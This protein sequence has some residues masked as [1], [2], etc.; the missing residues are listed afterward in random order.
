MK[1][2]GQSEDNNLLRQKAEAFL[3]SKKLNKN[4][5]Y[6]ETEIRKLIHELHVFQIE[7]EMQNE[8]FINAK[9]QAE[10]ESAKYTHL[11]DYAPSAYFT[12]NCQSEIIELNI[13]GSEMLGENRLHLINKQFS[14]FIS[15]DSMASFR[16]FLK[17]IF[18]HK[19][20]EYC[21]LNL[22][23]P[24]NSVKYIHLDGVISKDGK[25]C[26]V[27]AADL[28]ESKISSE[29]LFQS[30]ERYKALF[31]NNHA[32][33]LLID[34][35]NGKIK[36]A[37]P[38]ACKF[39][40]WSHYAICKK[41]ISEINTLS[42]EEINAEM[43]KAANEKRIQFYFNHRLA[44]GEIRNVEVNSGP[45]Q[46][47]NTKLLY[48]LIHDITA[49]KTIEEKLQK[50][51]ETYRNLVESISEAIY[52]IDC[53]GIIKYVSPSI[54]TILGYSEQEL[55]GKNFIEFIGE[56]AAHL[57]ARLHLLK[58]EKVLVNDYKINNNTGISKWIRFSSNAIIEDGIFKG[59]SG[60]LTDITERKNAEEKLKKSEE[61]YRML[62]ESI[63]DV[64]YEISNEGIVKYV[65]PS[66][67]RVLGYTADEVIG[68]NIIDFIY[69]EDK[70]MIYER[71]SKL[72]EKDYSYLE[73]RYVNKKGN[74]CWV[75][76]STNAIIENGKMTG[77][78]GMLTDIT[79]RKQAENALRE[80]ESLYRAILNASPED[81]TIADLNGNIQL[82]SPKGIIM[83]GFERMEQILNRN[84][85]EFLIPE[86]RER[87]QDVFLKLYQGISIGNAEYHGIKAD[88]SIF[89]I[90]V[91]AEFIRNSEGVPTNMVFI[92]RDITESV[93]AKKKLIEDQK[94]FRVLNELMSDYIFKLNMQSD[95]NYKMS[96]IAGNYTEATGRS[97]GEISTPSDW[98]NALHPDDL[99]NLYS[100]LNQVV[101]QKQAVDLECR[102]YTEDGKFRWLNVIAT[103]EIDTIS[104]KVIGIFGSVR[105]ITEKK[106]SIQNLLESEQKYFKLIENLHAG[107]VVH[108]PDSSIMFSNSEASELLG[109]SQNQLKGRVAIDT[110][111]YFM[112]EHG[113]KLAMEEYPVV[114]VISSLKPLLNQT[115]A[116][117]RPS[118][119]DIVWVQV[120]AYPEFT[121]EG[122]L[123]QVVVTF[124]DISEIIEAEKSLR[125][126]EEKYRNI[127]ENIL[128]VYY[129]A[130]IDGTLLEISPSIEFISKGQYNRD[131]LIGKS[132][133]SFYSDPE[134]R[135]RFFTYIKKQ[136]KVTDYELSFYNK[137]GTIV[138]ISITSGLLYDAEGNPV[139]IIGS[140]RD[141]TDRKIVEKALKE[142]ELNYRT[143]VNSGQALIWTATPDKKCN[144]FN[145]EWLD[146]TGRT[147][148]QELG[149]GWSEGVHPE[150]IERCFSI[151]TSSFDARKSFSMDYRMR[152]HDG[153]YHWL[154][155]DGKPRYNSLGEFIGYIGHC[156]D[157]TERIQSGIEIKNN[158]SVLSNLIMNMQE[159]ILLENF[160]RKILLCNQLFCDMYGIGAPPEVLVGADCSESAEQN[161]IYFRN[162]EKFVR[163]IELILKNKQ[164]VFNEELELM[165]GRFFER[166]YIPTY[167]EN[168]YNG[169]L[170]KYRDITDRKQNQ[171][172]IEES[173]ERFR[174]VVAQSEEVV[175]EVDANGLYTY[176]SPLAMQIY[177]YLPEQLVGKIHFYDLHPKGN[178]E[179]LKTAAFEMFSKKENFHNFINTIIRFDGREIT[180]STNGQPIIDEKGFLLGYR[181]LDADIT[182]RKRA[183]IELS[184]SEERYR[185]ITER[186]NDLIFIFRLKPE[187]GFDYVSPSSERITGYTPED[188]YKDPMLGMKLVHPD[189]LHLLK[190]LQNGIVNEE[191]NT[192]RW[193][194]KDG[195]I[196]WT[197]SQ[198]IPI[199]D[200]NGVLVAIQGKAIDVTERKQSEQIIHTR[201][202]LNEYAQTHSKNEIQQKLLDE[203]EKITNSQIG[204]FHF[205]NSDQRSLT[206]QCWSSNTVKDK[207]KAEGKG[208]HYGIDKAGVWVDCVHERKA[209]IHNDYLSLP[210]RKGLPEGHAKVVRELVVPVFRNEKI[211]AIVGIGNKPTDYTDKDVEIVS[212]L[213]D[214]AW[215]ITERIGAEE[216]LKKLSYAVEQSPVMICITDLAGNFEYANPK[217][218]EMTGYSSTELLGQNA[219]I[220]R[221]GEKSKD[222]YLKLW[223]TLRSGKEWHGEFHNK[224][225]NGELIWTSASL[226]PILNSS[227]KIMNFLAVQEDIT[228]RKQTEA[229]LLDLNTNLELK[230]NE[231]TIQLAE[232]N[233]SLQK[234]IEERKLTAEA[235]K[236]N[237]TL[238]QLM[239]NSS[240]LGF[241]VVDNR[242]DDILYFN[243]RFCQIWGIEAIADQM[244][245]GELK[246]NDIIPYCLPV[247]A[248]IPSFAESCKPLQFESNRIVLEDEIA[249]NDNRT[250]RRFSTQIRGE[251][252]IYYGRFYIFEDIS[253][254]KRSEKQ[255]LESEIKHSSM[256]S[257]ISDVIGIMGADG[258]MIYKSPN[259]ERYF[260]WKPEDLIGTDGWLTIH[261]DDLER[262]QS[263]F[264][265]LLHTDNFSKTVEYKYKCKDGSYKPIELTA[266]NL[267][268]DP[269][270]K[271]VLLNYHDITER[272]RV[273]KALRESEK[274]FSLFMDYLPA[275][276]FL[277]D[278]NGKTLFVNKYMETAFGASAWV[279]KTMLEV[280]PD[281][282]GEK[283][284]ED[285]KN[286][287]ALGYHKIEES[288]FQ[289]DGNLHR[290]ETQKFIIDRQGQ[291]PLL[292]GISLDIT[293][294]K[295]AEDKILEARDEA[296][297]ANLAKSEFLSRMSHEL[298]TP[299][300]S[301][302][303][304]AQLLEMG[305]LDV[306]QKK[307]VHHILQSGKHLLDMINEVLDIS[308]IE[309]GYLSLQF[310]P[311]QINNHLAE[312]LDII[313]PIA[314][315]KQ[316]N[317]QILDSLNDHYYVYAD[318]QRLK[319]VLLNLLNNAV[320]YNKKGGAVF[321]EYNEL[322]V[323]NDVKRYL[324]ISIKDT[325][326][327]ISADSINK[328]FIPFERIGAEKTE[329]EGTGLGLAVVKKLMD[330]ME[331][332]IGVESK[333][334][335]GSCFWI[336]LP[337]I[338]SAFDT[339][340]QNLENFKLTTA[341]EI[342]NNEIDIQNKEIDKQAIELSLA[343]EEIEFQKIE[344]GKR[345]AELM[346]A[347]EDLLLRD[348]S[349]VKQAAELILAY[350]TIDFQNEEKAKRNAEVLLSNLEMLLQS[351]EKEKLQSELIEAIRELTSQNKNLINT[352]VKSSEKKNCILYI[353][354]NES[355]IELVNQ[356]LTLHRPDICLIANKN[357][358]KALELAIA[359]K[360]AFI[361][362]DLNLPDIHGKEVLKLLQ[363]DKRSRNIPVVIISADAMPH[364]IDQLK[365][366]GSKEYL[367]KPLDVNTFLEIV[368]KWTVPEK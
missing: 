32:V 161:K 312:C 310:E 294:R 169:H 188:H 254:R 111:W 130:T 226:S 13:S 206:L 54:K 170:W 10:V 299:M 275:I 247:L 150:D 28:E 281:E 316:I 80:S 352:K 79:E 305:Q 287:M 68:T 181:G 163:D 167:N 8:E 179:Q 229:E 98:F 295:L 104:Q 20:K 106:V 327:G 158:S 46:F 177:G 203:L 338:N 197:E 137:D 274:M 368:D 340:K 241:L 149:D 304:F 199:Y 271:G 255:I 345:A 116:I 335:E 216:E 22:L 7:L 236:W 144:F 330:A 17:K 125:E 41:N 243:Q 221:S 140:M 61:N 3:K 103:P 282:L 249:F 58:E 124:Y 77:A 89:E 105:D 92:I 320:K 365:K 230:I 313:H 134:D 99:P 253:E 90:D 232:I 112:D 6:T 194:K 186:S 4:T 35:E 151:Y 359:N 59:A 21:A 319:Q 65:S 190:S 136:G 50:S 184:K 231:R 219:R 298:R 279:G 214:M 356:I 334:G 34:P 176:V 315:K 67:S 264:Y 252:D 306:K 242:T 83:F 256:I 26:L 78:S 73:Y 258:V 57:S 195:S 88:G 211:I 362:L 360:P 273:E 208:D 198:N 218:S 64:I 117:N 260:G 48:S 303:G 127:F 290:Y 321:I 166:D 9:E 119:N 238:L 286:S 159:G 138:P 23:T 122:L 96:V 222:E 285:D 261:P 12:L 191:V 189:D 84:I 132:I 153:S 93:A 366:A 24:D 269:V 143:L 250:V 168:K 94:I 178:R 114:K 364:Q 259:I 172:K 74:I 109:L 69:K 323:N 277:K 202:R 301:I 76:S 228:K 317:I 29:L 146:F 11:Y 160:D 215:D 86:D 14:S 346:I 157:I 36:D 102:S 27:T 322:P 325:G 337:I 207:C 361:L 200:V 348:K 234:E 162:P 60:T 156:L 267:V 45:V 331:G 308:R 248:D 126:N 75:R 300:N 39:Y 233:L 118:I 173:E 355:N 201:L 25:L 154:Q 85:N 87:A 224:R 82:V 192:L 223:E 139:K 326:I 145:Q 318:G 62:V 328:L 185:F 148:E 293:E 113:K 164:A 251:N 121:D 309:A 37:N 40:G 120:N 235:L 324:R 239:S 354:D 341:L 16:Y 81:I 31:H 49:K 272:K 205:V 265:H 349:D 131:E 66:V 263:E 266:T 141:I 332:N 358:K 100:N 30:E 56:S 367:C 351:E 115:F 5:H 1:K 213:S 289:L 95:G 182:D 339:R 43:Q 110:D 307:G 193:I 44:S 291:P 329:I 129:E 311:I 101:E 333:Q 72:Y 107:V 51:E 246:N 18:K 210:H 227:G 270:I 196:I 209:I 33:M 97:I 19:T 268:N 187:M 47:G 155:D 344:K 240:P 142:S 288:L 217:A 336:E 183:E 128:D 244:Q 245:R 171:L 175:W 314:E 63:N 350:E 180:V 353:E 296:E 2:T 280:F 38:A 70:L 174:Q 278:Q 55:I 204:F 133:L 302:L 357:G 52:E 71:I 283:L 292:G 237:Q 53:R 15:P 347:N 363:N 225:K 284:M 123:K 262:I 276:V 257:N 212:L 343:I 165:D 220:L 147:L 91:N 42:K 135:N 152:Y 342:A 297:K 108:S